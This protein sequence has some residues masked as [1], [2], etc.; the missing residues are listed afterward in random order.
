MRKT[1]LLIFTL[2]LVSFAA[3]EV[4]SVSINEL[5]ADTKV[6]NTFEVEG[7]ATGDN[8]QKLYLRYRQKGETSWRTIS[9]QEC[10]GEIACS[11]SDKSP[12]IEETSTYEYSVAATSDSDWT[13]SDIKEV[14]YYEESDDRVDSVSMNNLPSSKRA[15]DTVEIKG[16]ATGE[17]LDSIEIRKK[18]GFSWS[19]L[20]SKDCE[21]EIACSISEY[22]TSNVERDVEFKVRA[23]AGG[24]SD[25]TDSQ[26]ISFYETDP[27]SPEANLEISP[28]EGEIGDIFTFDASGSFGRDAE[29]VEYKFD[30]T[31]DG[32]WE[33]EGSENIWNVEADREI[34]TTAVVKVVDVNGLT[35]T[36]TASYTV[37]DPECDLSVENFEVSDTR[38]VTGE[39]VTVSLDVVN[40][41]DTEQDVDLSFEAGDESQDIS[42]VIPAEG[43]ELFDWSFEPEEDVDLETEVVCEGDSIFFDTT[44]IT[45]EDKGLLS[46]NVEDEN[47]NALEGATVE[48]RL[49][50]E[51]DLIEERDT[52]GDGKVSFSLDPGTYDV[53]ASKTGYRPEIQEEVEVELDRESEIDF[54]L[55][56]IPEELRI[57]DVTYRDPV[58]SGEDFEVSVTVENT[59]DR[60]Q[61]VRIQGEGLGAITRGTRFTVP[62]HDSRT[63]SVVFPNIQRDVS[64]AE[65]TFEITLEN[66][67]TDSVEREVEVVDCP[68]VVDPQ[69]ARGITLDISPRETEAGQPVKVAGYVQG[70]RRGKEVKI[71]L[72]GNHVDTVD[73]APDGYYEAFVRSEF[74]GQ[75]EVTVSADSQRRTRTFTASPTVEIGYMKTPR[76]VFQGEQFEVCGMDIESQVTPRVYLEEDGE[77]IDSKN[78]RGDVCFNVTT[79]ETSKHRYQ[80][81]AEVDS[82]TATMS[83]DIDVHRADQEAVNFPD[84]VATV[85]S[86]SGMVRVTLYNSNPESRTYDVE[87]RQVPRDWFS[88]TE[89]QVTLQPGEEQEVFFY[90]TPKDQGDFQGDLEVQSDGQS[91]HFER[92]DISSTRPVHNQRTFLDR[93]LSLFR[94]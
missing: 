32:N 86:G 14:T 48:V 68:G 82:E 78:E 51:D 5:P 89:K 77:I 33:E 79:H 72:N 58:C 41:M 87:L 54:T 91:V 47:E 88:Q 4:S 38:T 85:R 6:E 61:N 53:E 56:S 13:R 24:D 83:K 74:A 22:Y 10:E 21:Q 2:F 64:G 9:T 37:T 12:V 44:P 75:N 31:G 63:R 8:L 39:E 49:S 18:E 40:N 93:L 60:S 66:S 36:D 46:V 45:V 26:I 92:I 62:S 25:G 65:Q 84:R 34:S 1:L 69:A 57:D 59:M 70:V 73:T 23:E 52:G 42:Q 30:F 3:G 76:A 20:K 17:E 67:E 55:E 80:V 90:F 27:K 29:I 50:G 16:S 71:N 94:L 35:D 28:S 43:E 19:T 7:S 11:D 81:S 15:G